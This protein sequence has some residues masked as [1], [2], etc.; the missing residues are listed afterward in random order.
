MSWGLQLQ[1]HRGIESKSPLVIS[2]GFPNS[3]KFVSTLSNPRTPISLRHSSSGEANASAVAEDDFG[4]AALPA[5]L[6]RELMPRHVAVIMDGNS[7]WARRRGLPTSAGHES[8]ARSMWKLVDMCRRWGVKVLTVFAF[9]SE[10]W[11][12]SKM[13]VD[14][15]MSL[16]GIE[17]RGKM[18]K[19]MREEIRMSV[20]GE[21][22]RLP[23]FLRKIIAQAEEAT[24]ENTKLHLIVAINYS[25][26]YDI[27]QA[28]KSIA[29]K[30]KDGVVELK[31]IDDA[32]IEKELQTKCTE[33]PNPDL[34][35]R[36]S[37]ELRLSNFL[38][39]QLAY[40]ELFF[41]DSYW[42]DFGEVDFIMALRSFQKRDRRFGVREFING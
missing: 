21:K 42:P 12:R 1:L 9:S 5:G 24:K 16:F 7:R 20:I 38:L 23:A 29:L 39:W 10:N 19:M 8:G 36:T 22:S 14:F 2:R 13:E 3:P 26:R 27:V 17:I 35:I 15:L 37:G 28:C 4:E 11:K 25:G 34:L 31:G 18:E 40:A 30:A 6:R 33:F 41:A 32:L